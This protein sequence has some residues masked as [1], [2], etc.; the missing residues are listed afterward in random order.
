MICKYGLSTS[1]VSVTKKKTYYIINPPWFTNSITINP[2]QKPPSLTP[3]SEPRPGVTRGR[4]N[5][6]PK[7]SPSKLNEESPVVD[8]GSMVVR[9]PWAVLCLFKSVGYLGFLIQNLFLICDLVFLK[10]VFSGILMDYR[11]KTI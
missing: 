3:N 5:K 2:Q 7:E 11:C 4:A 9:K 8:G 1:S 10:G 6:T